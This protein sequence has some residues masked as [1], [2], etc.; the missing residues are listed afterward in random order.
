MELKYLNPGLKYSVDNIMMFQTA[1]D[2]EMWRVPLFAVYPQ[3]DRLH[4]DSLEQSQ[5][6]E[7]V[8]ETMQTVYESEEKVISEKIVEYN[9]HWKNNKDS[10]EAAFSEAFEINCRRLFS[11]M[12]GKISLNPIE[13]RWLESTSF[14]VFY[15]NSPSG[16]LGTALHE[17]VHFVWFYVWKHHFN[18][19][20]SEYEAPSLKWAFSEMV[21]DP[22]MRNDIR[23]SD[24]NPYFEDGC[25][26]AYFYSMII[27]E[28]PILETLYDMYT[29]LSIT[30]FMK[31]GYCYCEKNEADIRSQME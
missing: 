22:I 25:A 4:F 9:R 14:D 19:D 12:V 16:A 3:L 21:V 29:S 2:S 10:I 6:Y 20:S 1:E 28:K 24:R 5:Q 15:L 11:E 18:D 26:Y 7:Y 13:P 23:L 27:N 31:Q 8:F 30:E 17:I